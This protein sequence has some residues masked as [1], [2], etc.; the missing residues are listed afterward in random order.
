MKLTSLGIFAASAGSFS[1]AFSPAIHIKSYP[2]AKTAASITTLQA[3][4]AET[5]EERLRKKVRE[6]R[7]EVKGAEDEL[8]SNLIQKKKTRDTCTDSVITHLFP[9]GEDDAGALTDRLREK[10]LASDMLVGIVERL[11]E[12][13]VAARGLEHVE[14]SS[15]QDKVTFERVAEPN[16]AELQKLQGL[17]NRLIEAAEVLDK[18]FIDQKSACDGKIT[19]ADLM[20]WGGGDIAGILKEKAKDLGREHDEQF[21]Q[22]LESFYEAAKRKHTKDEIDDIDRDWR[23]DDVW[24]P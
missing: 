20:H 21:K 11:H 5:D 10:R 13:E 6:L 2:K 24:S 1:Q 8:H 17:V 9:S 12:R 7:E 4:T 3:T 18:E 22:R 15:N 16:E 19:H 23:G 14:Q